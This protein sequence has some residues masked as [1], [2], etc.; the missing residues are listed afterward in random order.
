MPRATMGTLALVLD[1]MD[2]LPELS[3][4]LTPRHDAALTAYAVKRLE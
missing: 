3:E 1:A 2:M 4:V